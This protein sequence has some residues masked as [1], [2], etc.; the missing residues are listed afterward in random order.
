[1]MK[2]V[3]I[4]KERIS[5]FIGKKG[6]TKRR[7]EHATETVISVN[8][9]ITID[10]DA[11]GVLTAETVIRAIGRGFSPQVAFRLLDED[12]TL[13][14]IE[15]P[16]KSLE[17]VRARIIGSSGKAKRNIERFTGA[18]VVVYG[19]TAAVIGDYESAERARR[20]IGMLIQGSEHKNVY[21]FLMKKR[22]HAR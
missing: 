9:G 5:V 20:A 18:D 6:E 17:R 21:G 7:I 13:H 10:G 8:E 2:T 11:L 15:I 14:V 12:T 16:K 3:A 1:M 19:K 22:K 4:P